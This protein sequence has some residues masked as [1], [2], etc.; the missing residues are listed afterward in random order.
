MK[1]LEALVNLS[2]NEGS[3]ITKT[4]QLKIVRTKVMMMNFYCS[5][6]ED[7]TNRFDSE[8]MMNFYCFEETGKTNRFDSD[9]R[10][11]QK[12]CKNRNI[13]IITS[14]E[15]RLYHDDDD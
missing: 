12:Q 5:E 15:L 9:W 10:T 8:M 2:A 13:I 6:K 3:S 7:K 11:K 4:L 14:K 1:A